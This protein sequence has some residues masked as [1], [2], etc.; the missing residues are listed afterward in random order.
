MHSNAELVLSL[1]VIAD[2]LQIVHC[3]VLCQYTEIGGDVILAVD[4]VAAGELVVG[5]EREFVMVADEIDGAMLQH[6]EV[7]ALNHALHKRLG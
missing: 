7:L 1:F 3:L 4:G 2:V 5:V 6:S